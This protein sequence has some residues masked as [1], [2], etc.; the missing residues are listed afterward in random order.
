MKKVG[1]RNPVFLLDEIDKLSSENRGD[2]AAALLEVLDP[3]QNSTFTDHYLELPFDLSEVFFICTGNVKYQ[4][5]RP[6]ADR[7]DIIDLP[8]YM[9]EEKVNIGMRH[10]LPKVLREHGL[11]SDQLKISQ[12]MMQRIITDYTREAGVRTLDRQ[13]AAI[14][15]KAAYRV[16]EK[17]NTHLSITPKRLEQYLGPPRYSD[18]PPLLRNMVGAAMGMAVMESGGILLPVEVVTMV[19]KGDLQVTGQLGDVMRE[20]AV[21]A[22]SYIRTRANDLNI[23]PSFQDTTDIHIHLPEGALPKDGPSAGITIAAALVSAL[24][25]RPVRGDLAMTGEI[26]LLG[27]VLAI[28]GLKEKV[29]A[30]QQ[31]NIRHLIVPAAN[32]KELAEIPT[33]VR[34]RIDFTFVD[35]MDQVIEKALLEAPMEESSEKDDEP[36]PLR[37]EDRFAALHEQSQR[38][39]NRSTEIQDEQ[40]ESNDDEANAFMIPPPDRTTQDSFPRARA[41]KDNEDI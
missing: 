28:G 18:A 11:T 41:R 10:L 3:E 16:L 38:R 34:Q 9:L 36:V 5:P 40:E 13:L 22:L 31:A 7:M 32:K 17:P 20:S 23:D 2:P 1:V 15:R 24:T 8:G 35:N 33:K 29:L 25:R 26:T 21:T 27:S 37:L 14:C 12:S 30:A 39:T 19:G 6:L 4:I